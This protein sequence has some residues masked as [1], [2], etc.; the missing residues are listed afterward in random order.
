LENQTRYR[1]EARMSA[2]VHATAP[3]IAARTFEHRF[4][5]LA[6][7]CEGITAAT[8]PLL[9]SHVA[10]RVNSGAMTTRQAERLVGYLVL[11]NRTGAEYPARTSRRRRSELRKQGLVLADPLTDPIEVDLA[12]GLDAALAAW[13]ACG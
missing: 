11:Q 10:D 2:Q 6:A 8:L 9:A 3:E 7:S 12:E 4:A 5:P 1:K 13:S